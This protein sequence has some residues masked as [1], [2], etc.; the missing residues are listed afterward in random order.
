MRAKKAVQCQ[1]QKVQAIALMM[2]GF[3]APMSA[4]ELIQK[5]SKLDENST[6]SDVVNVFGKEPHMIVEA[7]SDLWEYFSGDIRIGL[8][9]INPLDGL[10]S[11]AT[12]SH[13]DSFI[14]IDL[15]TIAADEQN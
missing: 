10:L 5:L 3:L 6:M 1:I 9:G 2:M 7:N 4:E 13:G 11:R 15:L 8:S 14:A 12:V